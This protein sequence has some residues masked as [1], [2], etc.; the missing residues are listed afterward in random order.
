MALSEPSRKR[1]F[2]FLITGNFIYW[3][4]IGFILIPQGIYF[5]KIYNGEKIHTEKIV[6]K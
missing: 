6:I 2:G 1:S 4:I 3:W 5:A